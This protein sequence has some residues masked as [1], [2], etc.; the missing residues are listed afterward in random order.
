MCVC[1]IGGT[2]V[3]R[4]IPREVLMISRFLAD[5]VINHGKDIFLYLSF[6]SQ[7]TIMGS[8][9]LEISENEVDEKE[10]K[11]LQRSGFIKYNRVGTKFI[12]F[13]KEEGSWIK[14]PP[15]IKRKEKK[16]Q[17]EYI[18]QGLDTIAK[19]LGYPIDWRSNRVKYFTQYHRLLK[20]YSQNELE[21][22][23]SFVADEFPDCDLQGFISQK[24][25]NFYRDQQKNPKKI[26]DNVADRAEQSD[27]SAE[28][29]F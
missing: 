21:N 29:P 7:V 8:D 11:N 13:L 16:R 14:M 12:V 10:L 15:E 22:L 9:Q 23:A 28:Q 6:V 1:G 19:T 25:I 2:N 5:L 18:P 17:E 26:S 3:D 4:K 27:Y 24:S 20:K